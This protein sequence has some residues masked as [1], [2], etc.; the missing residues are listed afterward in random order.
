MDRATRLQHESREF[1][2]AYK[3]LQDE[4]A[5]RQRRLPRQRAY[6]VKQPDDESVFRSKIIGALS[7]PRP[8]AC[9]RMSTRSL[10]RRVKA[11]AVRLR[12]E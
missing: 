7:V 3:E 9:V 11:T 12:D 5:Q 6:K 10:D 2:D 1:M 8:V 4:Q